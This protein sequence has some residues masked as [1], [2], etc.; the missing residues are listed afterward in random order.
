MRIISDRSYAPAGPLDLV[1]P[2]PSRR[3]RGPSRRQHRTAFA[4]LA[5]GLVGLSILHAAAQS[6]QRQRDWGVTEPIWVM[7]HDLD[8]GRTI[9]PD[10]VEHRTYPAATVPDD[11]WPGDGPSPVGRTAL[12][13]LSTGE[14]LLRTRTGPDGIDGPTALVGEDR[15]ALALP[16]DVPIGGLEVGSTVTLF[17]A[18]QTTGWS[19]A[20]PNPEASRPAP[21]PEGARVVAVDALVVALDDGSMTVAIRDVE[22]AAVV[23]ALTAG[24]VIPALVG[25]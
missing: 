8:R 9:A 25:Q 1:L 14:L 12:V 18:D 15:L 6:E 21:R 23:S 24:P 10:D 13:D 19:A 22:A 2:R 3:P 5:A 11:A 16:V 20:A 7:T 17:A 4:A